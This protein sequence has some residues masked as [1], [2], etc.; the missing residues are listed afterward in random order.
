MTL[1][2]A[3]WVPVLWEAA[4]ADRMP[5]LLA[6]MSMTPEAIAEA[7]AAAEAAVRRELRR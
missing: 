5:P 6:Q 3:T 4:V 1:I 2:P 7:R